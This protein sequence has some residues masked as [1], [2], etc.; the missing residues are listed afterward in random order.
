MKPGDLVKITRASF[1]APSGTIGLITRVEAPE[2]NQFNLVYYSV[3]LCGPEK[4]KVRRYLR[5]DIRPV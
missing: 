2:D 5:Q 1:G 4:T 3:Q